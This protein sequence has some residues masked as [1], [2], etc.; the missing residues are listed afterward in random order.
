[1]TLYDCALR[2][3]PGGLHCLVLAWRACTGQEHRRRKPQSMPCHG[4]HAAFLS[5]HAFTSTQQLKCA[6]PWL[7]PWAVPQPLHS[8]RGL[9]DLQRP[10]VPN[11]RLPGLSSNLPYPSALRTEPKASR[12]VR[13]APKDCAHVFQRPCARLPRTVLKG[14]LIQKKPSRQSSQVP[15]AVLKA[16]IQLHMRQLH[17][18]HGHEHRLDEATCQEHRLIQATFHQQ[19]FHKSPHHQKPADHR[20]AAEQPSTQLSSV[21][22]PQAAA[23]HARTSTSASLLASSHR[24]ACSALLCIGPS[25]SARALMPWSLHDVQGQRTS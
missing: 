23:A 4:L 3:A 2:T 22:Q 8:L 24:K 14:A 17:L 5:G 20:S 15:R 25:L 1:M 12:A 19:P 21:P 11:H 9:P 6:F 13:K 7:C 10:S 16:P 18:S